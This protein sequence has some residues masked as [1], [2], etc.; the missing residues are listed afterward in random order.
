MRCGGKR[1]LFRIS[2]ALIRNCADAN[3]TAFQIESEDAEPDLANNDPQ[4]GVVYGYRVKKQLTPD[5]AQLKKVRLI[6][7]D[8]DSYKT[9]M[10]N[11]F[12][13][14]M[15]FQF[16]EGSNTTTVFI[17]T[18]CGLAYIYDETKMRRMPLT[19][20]ACFALEDVY[21]ALFHSK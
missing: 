12:E 8:L 10:P 9:A 2:T 14:G 7:T 13:P 20:A 21:E 3:V 16:R 15:I 11:C 1:K 18:F 19:R 4:R 6:I 5:P 17:C